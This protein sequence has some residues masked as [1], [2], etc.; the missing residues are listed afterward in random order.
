MSLF[1]RN[2]LTRGQSMVLFAMTMMITTIM[3][4]MT[5]SF[6]TKAKEKMELQV[7]TD[8]AAYST[9]VAV[10]RAYNQLSLMN[11]VSVA[12]QVALMGVNSSISFSTLAFGILTWLFLDYL[13][14]M[15]ANQAPQCNPPFRWCGCIGLIAVALMRVLPIIMRGMALMGMFMGLD[16][17]A[18]Q[19]ANGATL[20]TNMMYLWQMD[21]YALKLYA[22]TLTNQRQ[23]KDVVSNANMPAE[24]SAPG[25]ADEVAKRESGIIPYVDGAVNIN[26][27]ILTDRHMVSAALGSRGH[28][29]TAGRFGQFPGFFGLSGASLVLYNYIRN[30]TNDQV[31]QVVENGASYDATMWHLNT[32][33]DSSSAMA[34]SD[35]HMIFVFRYTGPGCSGIPLFGT[36]IAS[37]MGNNVWGPHIG[38]SGFAVGFPGEAIIFF[39]VPPFF[40]ADNLHI[41]SDICLLNCPS[42]YSS[43]VDYNNLALTNLIGGGEDLEGQP[44]MPV[45]LQRDYSARGSGADPWNLFF[46]FRFAAGGPGQKI[47]MKLA[48]NSGRIIMNDGT[49]ITVQTTMATGLA[50]YH[51]TGERYEEPPNMLN[52]YWHATVVHNDIDEQA[53]RG[54]DIPNTLNAAGQAPWAADAFNHLRLQGY[55]GWQ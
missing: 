8:Q 16:M 50:Y 21:I 36:S 10:A 20:A 32:L 51:R 53:A 12:H 24:I 17:A 26:N 11:R 30:I 46:N 4:C 23:A 39:P 37:V 1:N 54:N 47:N 27:L 34:I 45:V 44:K 25:G 28:P 18:H 43:F 52:P 15:G 31:M 9:T 3:V 48:N 14:E 6:A 7:L 42:V 29:W 5:L 41:F 38:G 40:W 33:I 2:K 49:D 13:I 35:D 55:K 19:Q 22:M